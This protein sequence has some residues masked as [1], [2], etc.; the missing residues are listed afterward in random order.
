M[1]KNNEFSRKVS[2]FH[3]ISLPEEGQ[4]VGYA[5]L[6]Q[7]I[8][9]AIGRRLPTP[10]QLAMVT[11]KQQR[12]DTDRWRVFGNRYLPEK[13]LGAHL[14]F[15][16]K[17]EG[18]DLLILKELFLITGD[19]FVEDMVK[20]EPTGQY[21]RRLWFLYEWLI[22]KKIAL[23]DAKAGNYV[24]VISPKLQYPGPTRNST[25]HRIKNNLPGT[26][27]FCPMV[28]RTQKLERYIAAKFSERMTQGLKDKNREL[29]QRTAAFLLLKDSKASFAIEGEHPP[30]LRA[31]NW[32]KAIGQAGKKNL[33]IAEIIRLQDMV[34]GSKK[35]KQMGI[36]TGEGFIGEHDRE[37]F[38]P[39]PDHISAR[40]K[41]LPQLMQGLLD[42]STLLQESDFDPVLAATII[43]FAFVFIHPLSDGN[44][45]I[46]RYLIHHILIRM[47]YTRRD[48]IF[49]VSAAILKRIAQYQDTLEAYSL[50]LLN[51]IEW[52]PTP[53]HNIIIHNETIDLYRYFDATQQ[54]EFLY[55][56]VQ[57]TIETIIPKELDFL[58]NYD[59]LARFINSTV[60]LPNTRVDLLIKLLHQNGGKLSKN[61]RL[62]E[63]EELDDKEI[64]SI[65]NTYQ[66]IF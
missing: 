2:V 58:E 61:K 44:G 8:E 25:R 54:A 38:T 53:D 34:I 51:L 3:G 57:E 40:A 31:R 19:G 43:A 9:E 66:S 59:R 7:Y 29:I 27:Q 50:P 26:S 63:F 33:S 49:P 42:T 23:P 20:S 22:G 46:H 41:D 14:V 36:R 56:C 45:R 17:H 28:R 37:T 4:L 1:I 24:E 21:S 60:T 15:A 48:M 52:E 12:Y 35:L 32:G 13:H 10:K 65:Q 6:L 11:D 47:G 30:N 62:K 55:D 16:L 5:L 64:D 18:I 39:M